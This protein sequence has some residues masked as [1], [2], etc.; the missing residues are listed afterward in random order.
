MDVCKT[1]KRRTWALVLQSPWPVQSEA[2]GFVQAMPV[3]RAR[4]LQTKC[5]PPE[6]ETVQASASDQ[7]LRSAPP[8]PGSRQWALGGDR[9]CGRA[10]R[11]RHVSC[12]Q[13]RGQGTMPFALAGLL[14]WAV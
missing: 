14:G 3:R 10:E 4:L 12:G 9:H 5:A 2:T 11:D 13:G 1:H 6:P 7:G 8:S